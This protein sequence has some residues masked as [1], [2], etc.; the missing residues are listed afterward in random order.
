MRRF[1]APVV[2]QGGSL[3]LNSHGV[4]LTTRSCLLESNRNPRLDAAELEPLLRDYLGVKRLAWPDDPN[5]A[6]TAENLELSRQP[7]T[8]SGRPYRSVE[9]RLPVRR[10]ELEGQRSPPSNANFYVGNGFVVVPQDGDI[11]DEPGREVIGLGAASLIT[12]GGAFHCVTHQQPEG[13]PERA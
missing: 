8:P 13:E 3:E 7:R 1:V 11:N 10:M 6:A 9:L 5:H 4:C 12:G 2:M